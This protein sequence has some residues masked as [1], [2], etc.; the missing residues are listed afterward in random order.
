MT[1]RVKLF[2]LLIVTLAVSFQ[3]TPAQAWTCPWLC[4]N[5]YTHCVENCHVPR[6]GGVIQD[7]PCAERCTD[8]VETCLGACGFWEV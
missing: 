5:A 1:H 7:V 6:P 8:T 3:A 4:N 2:C